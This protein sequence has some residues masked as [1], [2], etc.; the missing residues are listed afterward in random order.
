VRGGWLEFDGT[1]DLGAYE[2]LARENRL[3]FRREAASA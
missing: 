2:K 3:S 1:A